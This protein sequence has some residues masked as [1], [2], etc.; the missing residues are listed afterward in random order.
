M[1]RTKLGRQEMGWGPKGSAL[2]T[3][4]QPPGIGTF[5]GLRLLCPTPVIPDLEV[6]R[7]EGNPHSKAPGIMTQAKVLCVLVTALI[8]TKREN[9]FLEKQS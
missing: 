1:L 2:S 8:S 7:A 6:V 5:Q 9:V 3:Q 4:S